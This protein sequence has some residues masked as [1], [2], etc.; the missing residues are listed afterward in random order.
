MSRIV[1]VSTK[2]EI[3][4]TYPRRMEG[5][6]PVVTLSS[7]PEDLTL[8]AVSV[9]ESPMETHPRKSLSTHESF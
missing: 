6:S 4:Q 2:F 1:S 9:D 8:M 5:L 3:Y 7:L